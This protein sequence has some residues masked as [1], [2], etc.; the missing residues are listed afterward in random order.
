MTERKG[1]AWK[2]LQIAITQ[3]VEAAVPTEAAGQARLPR[4][5]RIYSQ[6]QRYRLNAYCVVYIAHTLGSI[7][8]KMLASYSRRCII[9]DRVLPSG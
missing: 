3:A 4:P 7:S 9:T 8:G 2:E 6:S 1:K 5:S